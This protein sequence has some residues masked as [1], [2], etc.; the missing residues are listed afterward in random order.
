MH[1]RVVY[2]HEKLWAARDPEVSD[3]RHQ[4]CDPFL[5][6]LPLAPD[7]LVDQPQPLSSVL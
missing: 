1:V 7:L 6:H 5:V 3:V 4:Q 2:E